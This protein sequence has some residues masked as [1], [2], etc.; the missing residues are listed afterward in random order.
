MDGVFLRH[1]DIVVTGKRSRR[2]AGTDLAE[3]LGAGVGKMEVSFTKMGDGRPQKTVQVARRWSRGPGS[4]TLAHFDQ[5]MR[6]SAS[7]T[8]A[9][10]CLGCVRLQWLQNAVCCCVEALTFLLN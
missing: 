7:G 6:S 8:R 4:A 2:L 5:S 1:T 10:V 3:V 9:H